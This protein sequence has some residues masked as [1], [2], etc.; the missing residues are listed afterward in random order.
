MAN[1]IEHWPLERLMPYARNAKTHDAV[2]VAKIAASI[3]EM[4]FNNPILVDEASGEII[5]GHGRLMAAQRLN[6][7]E[8]P[9]V[10]LTHMTEDQRR[11]YV[12]AN[13]KLAELGGWDEEMLASELAALESSGFDLDLT[14][15]DADEL[16]G[17]L[18]ELD[19]N[20]GAPG[21][22][23]HDE[24]ED[25]EDDEEPQQAKQVGALRDRFGVP[26]FT[27]LSARDG[28]WQ[29]RK[30]G[31][32]ALGIRSELGRDG[33][34]TPTVNSSE[35][36]YE[37][38]SGR[39][40]A[41]GGSVFDPV[42]TELAYRWFCPLGGTIIDPFAGGSVR[43][44]VAAKLGRNYH[45][46]ELRA[47]QVE[48]NRL[49][50]AEMR[51]K[52]GIE[53][54]LPDFA[55]DNTPDLTPVEDRGPYR[56][57]RDDAFCVGG[58]RGGKVRTCWTLAQGAQ[59]LVTAGSRSSPQVNIVAQV[60]RKLGIPCRV[61][62]PQGELSPEVR[63]A[64]A[65]GAEV[66][67]HKAGYNNVIIARAREDAAETGWREIPFG[68]E[69]HA[70]IHATA[71]QVANLPDD[72]ERIVVPVGSGM[73]LAG[74]L[75]GLKQRGLDVPVV[76]VRVG[77]D[78]VG[79]LDEYAPADWRDMV[80]LVESGLDYHDSAPVTDLHGLR[81]DPIYEAKCLPHL[82]DGDLLWV[83]GIRASEV[84]AAPVGEPTWHNA[85]SRFIT[86]TLTGV[87]GDMV[88]SCPP[89]ADLE[90]YSDD[91]NDLST[92]G[93]EEFKDAY[94]EI[95]RET[96]TLLK[97]NRFACFVVGD[98][99]D[100]RGHY[101]NFVGDTVEAFR[102]AGLHYYN[103][104]ILVTPAGTLPLRAGKQ[105]EAGRKMGK[106]HQN[107]LVFVKGDAKLATQAIG[108]VEFGAVD[109]VE[110]QEE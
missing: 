60:A 8:V 52:S 91:P 18:G 64:Q 17:L 14:G 3:T 100:K 42:M 51:D 75:H 107:I 13:N 105:F 54:P 12:L 73:S 27:V 96:C 32:M 62:T 83:V 45:G 48:A 4:G 88:F 34:A 58:G 99:R 87:E 70:A 40:N 25:D 1:K 41:E 20:E 29:A 59:G 108:P 10:P 50:W 67:Q 84:V 5:A 9:V 109:G 79:R 11:A 56:V 46:S 106:T 36:K 39:G 24:D 90:V 103:E 85:D 104:A 57:K 101:Y 47:E 69:C 63:M 86:Q 76:G 19:D 33:L 16:D 82:Q 49:Q 30:R 80:T 94:F 53:I 92:L 26:P 65:A 110:D 23:D 37:Y 78:P 31:W 38:F 97:D 15:F 43:G 44:V 6:M 77:A 93:Y 102:A 21:D 55:D 66:V 22:R 98:V 71:G 72:I 28:W 81:L 89:Y 61:H 35:G 68:M 7:D 2:Q 95:I 74:I